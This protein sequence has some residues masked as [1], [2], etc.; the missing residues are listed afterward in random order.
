M[1]KTISLLLVAVMLLAALSGCSST[2]GSNNNGE[3]TNEKDKVTNNEQNTQKD[4]SAVMTGD[5]TVISREE[6]SG[7]RGAFI[8][9]MGIEQKDANGNKVDMTTA[10]AEITNSTAVMLT[11][12]QGNTAAIGYVSLGS[13]DETMV[14]ALKI[15]GVEATVDN[16]KSG[17]Y[18]VSRPFNIATLGDVSDTAQ[19]FIDYIMSA[20]GQAIIEG[21]GYIS[22]GNTGAY[23]NNSVAGSISIGGSSSVSPVMEKLAE[24]YMA[25]NSNVTIEIQTS[26]STTG[27]TSAAE[28]LFDIGMASRGLKDSEIDAGLTGTTICM[29]GIAVIV[30]LDNPTD[31]LTKEQVCSIYTGE[32]TSWDELA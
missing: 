13:L 28:G 27:M 24:S 7:T 23:V 21:A 9:L 20:D 16:I 5:I 17:E 10:S 18:S 19:D 32:V 4:T 14:K 2:T 31:G 30:N 29:D 15:D 11:T 12:V 3:N 6:G 22:Q 25:I 8:E 26:D 1:K